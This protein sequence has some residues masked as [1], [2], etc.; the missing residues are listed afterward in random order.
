MAT[1]PSLLGTPRLW[2]RWLVF[3]SF[4]FFSRSAWLK[5]QKKKT[6]GFEKRRIWYID[7]GGN[8]VVVAFLPH[9]VRHGCCCVIDCQNQHCN[10]RRRL[11]N[12]RSCTIQWNLVE[13]NHDCCCYYCCLW[14]DLCAR[15]VSF[16]VPVVFFHRT[17]WTGNSPIHPLLPPF[18]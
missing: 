7:L 12:H 5:K 6:H 4:C 18:L 10:P 8:G 1:V 13:S 9:G 2:Y 16:S 3:P 17:N 15:G 14:N 11:Q